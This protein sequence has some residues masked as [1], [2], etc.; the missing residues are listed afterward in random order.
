MRN[1]IFTKQIEG[2]NSYKKNFFKKPSGYRKVSDNDI[3]SSNF[4][5][6]IN[7]RRVSV[8]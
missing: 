6:Q 2:L 4:A 8:P 1:I 3:R 5:K 7:F